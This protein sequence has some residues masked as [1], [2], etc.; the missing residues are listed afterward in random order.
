MM[1]CGSI[2]SIDELV[3][4]MLFECMMIRLTALLAS[5]WHS[6]LVDLGSV[7]CL[8]L[9]S[10]LHRHVTVLFH[11]DLGMADVAGLCFVTLSWICC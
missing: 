1:Y 9:G 11:T 4:F 6:S 5:G 2:Y 8:V 7:V 10:L 3:Y